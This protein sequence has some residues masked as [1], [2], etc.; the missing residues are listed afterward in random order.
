MSNVTTNCI[1]AVIMETLADSERIK[2]ASVEEIVE[3][4]THQD[5]ADGGVCIDIAMKD[6]RRFEIKTRESPPRVIV[7]ATPASPSEYGV[8][9]DGGLLMGGF[10]TREDA[11]SALVNLYSR[12]C[13]RVAMCCPIHSE[14]E[15]DQCE[16]CNEQ[17]DICSR[18]SGNGVIPDPNYA[19]IF[20]WQCPDCR[21]MGYSDS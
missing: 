8:F 6:G 7:E 10:D 21:G 20:N 15:H 12:D 13:P 11:A 2:A 5:T 14:F 19:A 18:C 4:D 9:D 1:N 16:A 3:I 17:D